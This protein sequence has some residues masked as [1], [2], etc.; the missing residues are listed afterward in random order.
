MR[1]EVPKL[2]DVWLDNGLATFTILLEEL[3]DDEEILTSVEIN[4]DSIVYSFDDKEKFI[5]I[6]S[7]KIESKIWNMIVEG[8]D[9]K[10]NEKKEIKKDHIL[11]Q[12]NSKLGGKVAFK[13][14]IFAT[15]KTFKVITEVFENL[16]EGKNKCFFCNRSF[17]KS[18]KKIQQASYPFVTKVKSLSGI[19]SGKDL[20]MTEYISEYCPQCYLLGIL[21]WLDESMVYRNLPGEKSIIILPNKDNLKELIQLK[22]TNNSNVLDNAKRWSNILI[23]IG[24]KS[25]DK[26]DSPPNKY[27]TFISFYESFLIESKHEFDDALWYIIEIP[28]GSVKNPKYFNV[29]FDKETSRIIKTLLRKDKLY[30]YRVFIKEFYA[31]HTD[32]KKGIRNFDHE[33]ELQEKLCES[34]IKDDFKAFASAFVPRKGIKPGISK[35]AYKVLENLINYWRIEPMKIEN[36]EEYIKNLGAAGTSLANLI[37]KRL[38]LFFKLE[39]AKNPSDFLSALQEITRRLLIDDD[40]K[41]GKVYK[42][43]ISE[44]TKMIVE[45]QDDKEFFE[46]TKNILLIYTCLRTKKENNNEEEN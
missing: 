43:S 13:E 16:E 9:K 11:I 17:K 3:N 30:F 39:K 19:R 44:V 8:E 14:E 28:A 25:S 27:T 18:I 23:D 34:F 2:N 46:T 26:T 5:K 41:F 7:R 42:G 10:T 33:K 36:K 1:I 21:E 4:D 38:S 45:R 24:N 40:S 12:E 6:F 29:M 20:N 32:L 31:F 15:G 35:D 37:E 22:R